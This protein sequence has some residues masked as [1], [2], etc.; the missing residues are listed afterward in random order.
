MKKIYF[1]FS[2][3]LI[4]VFSCQN[5]DTIA[6]QHIIE[7][8]NPI[9]QIPDIIDFNYHVK[10]ILSDR[11]FKCHGPDESKIEAGLSFTNYES[12]TSVL[13]EKTN[14]RAIVP[15]NPDDS[16]L[17]QRIHS[18]DPS[19]TMPP[20][21]SNLSLDSYE[22]EILTKWIL[23]GAKYAKHWSFLPLKQDFGSLRKYTT[24]KNRIDDF[25]AAK[26]ET[27]PLK[28]SPIAE[29]EYLIRRVAFTL[30]GLP[31]TEQE[32]DDFLNNKSLD[33]YEA[34]ID[35]Y[36]A[37]ESYGEHMA[38]FWM[39]LSRYADTHGYQ[40]DLE[41]VM[42]PWRDWVIHAY[43]TNMPY[44]QFVT[45]QLAG[46]L[47]PEANKEQ[48]IATAFNRNHSITQEGGVIP[49]E[50]RT[51]YVADRT[52][53]FGKSFLGLSMECA[54]CHD[55]KY[56]PISQEDYYSMFAFFNNV[57][58][59]GLI[60]EYGAIP[61]PYVEITKEEVNSILTFINNLDTLEK[62]PLMVMEEMKRPRDTYVLE[63]GLYNRPSKQVFPSVPDAI[64][65]FK[66]YTQNRYGLTEWLFDKENPLTARVAVNRLWKIQA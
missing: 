53:T 13:D 31:P 9:V 54:R 55:H 51:E 2:L 58:E 64:L 26:L 1:L 27:S 3:L 66:D 14:Q 62:I 56:D 12:A 29:K 22:K 44:D 16:E 10:P 6:S 5:E 59:K 38:S 63:R 32:I 49:E 46:D 23:Q 39:D 42:W 28:P 60:E 65:P 35:Y 48:I 41:R 7:T 11:C 40:D 52:L 57:P 34:L 15:G 18:L 45:Y 36:L 47:I 25:I 8:E 43:N 20:P 24:S 19:M 21:E 33:A 4:A 30:T 17:V 50:Y 37:K 61:E